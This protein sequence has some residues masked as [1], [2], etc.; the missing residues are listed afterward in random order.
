MH[1]AVQRV[2]QIELLSTAEIRHLFPDST[3]H[4]ERMAGMTKSIVAVR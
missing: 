1:E 4:R 2:L 3:L